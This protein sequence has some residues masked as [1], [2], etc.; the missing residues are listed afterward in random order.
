MNN[1]EKLHISLKGCLKFNNKN[2][3]KLSSTDRQALEKV[4]AYLESY[5]QDISY[6]TLMPYMDEPRILYNKLKE[7]YID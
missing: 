2:L 6:K 1:N 3:E 7:Y 5:N 4:F